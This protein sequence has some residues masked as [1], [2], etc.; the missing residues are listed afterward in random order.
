M[1]RGKEGEG[2]RGAREK[3]E[4]RERHWT[5]PQKHSGL[6]RSSVF[7]AQGPRAQSSEE[8]TIPI[9]TSL[10]SYGNTQLLTAHI[11]IFRA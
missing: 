5:P 2:N 9:P 4:G 7:Q 1:V 8:A 11:L 6:S 10:R 3:N